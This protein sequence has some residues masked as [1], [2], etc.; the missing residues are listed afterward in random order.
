M[1]AKPTH[2]E[3]RHNEGM[4][5][6]V[7][8]EIAGVSVRTIRHYHDVGLLPVPQQRRGAWRV[9]S[10]DDL[11]RLLIIRTLAE[12][13]VPLSEIPDYLCGKSSFDQAIERIDAQI[14]TLQR[15]R[16]RLE[17]LKQHPNAL[18][19]SLI[20]ATFIPIYDQVERELKA[21]GNVEALRLFRKKRRIDELGARL[22]FFH[23][24]Y[25]YYFESIGQ[26][27]LTDFYLRF[28]KL[29]E[30]DWTEQECIDLADKVFEILEQHGPPPESTFAAMRRV[31]A[32]RSARII[33]RIA[34]P[35]PGQQRFIEI[36]F[37]RYS[38]FLDTLP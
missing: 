16:R 31:A 34:Y 27:E 29:S 10:M 12:A 14:A 30:N 38:K 22:G 20:P 6:S 35:A 19:G 9:Y 8:A 25:K 24:D 32:S 11:E 23:P 37:E 28:A 17:S 33:A 18:S 4:K 36:V 26:E 7:I 13:G 21:T 2:N 15:H 3:T 5:I 1:L